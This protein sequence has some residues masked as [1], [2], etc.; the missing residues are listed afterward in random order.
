M[1]AAGG[2]GQGDPAALSRASGLSGRAASGGR[3]RKPALSDKPAGAILRAGEVR[4]PLTF[5]HLPSCHA[6]F[7]WGNRCRGDSEGT[8]SRWRDCT[9]VSSYCLFPPPR[10][11]AKAG[12]VGDPPVLVAGSFPFGKGDG[13]ECPRL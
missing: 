1:S 6:F 7:T 11:T 2:R 12:Q 13:F 5:W 9:L 3:G 8:G 10:G 4:D